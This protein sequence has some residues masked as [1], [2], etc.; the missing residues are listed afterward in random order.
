MVTTVSRSRR[1]DRMAALWLRLHGGME[2][3]FAR[4][5]AAFFRAQTQ[6]LIHGLAA[7]VGTVMPHDV[8][9]ALDW[10]AEH[11]RFIRT[12]V[13]P[14]LLTIATVG[15]KVQLQLL[16]AGKLFDGYMAKA[17]DDDFGDT[18]DMELPAAVR[19]AIQATVEHTLQQPYWLKIEDDTREVAKNA[20]E[21][22]FDN[23]FSEGQLTRLI[24]QAMND[25]G[26]VRAQRIA[27]TETTAAANGG[28]DAVINSL[29]AEGAPILKEWTAIADS[30]C[31]QSHVEMNG[32]RVKPGEPF[33]V[34]PT[35]SPAPYPGYSG[36]PP[37]ER[38]NCRCVLLSGTED[39]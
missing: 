11:Q 26:K 6:R 5:I 37:E 23:G 28:H 15:A 24:E 38:I 29:A 18:V 10:H 25:A 4:A 9:G 8:D 12:V 3:K 17:L 35:R 39:E 27:R 16:R 31:R 32:Q 2:R 20:I 36:L 7:G 30:D 22:A 13:R 34:G 21:N 1:T 19:A 33:L 14:H